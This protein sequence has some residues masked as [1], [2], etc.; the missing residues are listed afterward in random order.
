MDIDH[1]TL[2]DLSV[3]HPEENLSL[4]DKFDRTRTTG[5]RE[6]LRKLFTTPLN[7]IAEIRETQ[8]VLKAIALHEAQW[9]KK[10]SNGSVMMIHKFFETAV[11]AIPGY[12]STTEAYMYKLLH[13]PDYGLVKFSAGHAFDFLSGMKQITDIFSGADCPGILSDLIKRIRDIINKPQLEEVWRYEKAED[14]S[15]A[16]MLAFASYVRYHFK[17]LL[18]ELI[19]IYSLLDAWYGM[20]QAVK[21]NGL[22]YPEF[23]ESASPLLQLSNLFHPLLAHPVPYDVELNE[24]KN[25]IFL[26]GANMAGKSTFI[27]SVGVAIYLAHL[28]MG[29]PASSM[30]MSL[31][32]GLLTNINV[33]DNIVKGESYFYSEVTRVKNTV[34]KVTD[35]RKWMVLI[36]ELFKGTNIQDAM[37]CS[38]E[39]INGLVRVRDSFFILSTH[40]Y[41]ISDDL[42]Q[43]SN[44]DFQYFETEVKGDKLEF[45]Y[46]LKPGISNDRLGYFILK[47]EKVIEL[48]EKI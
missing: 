18:Y 9:P 48:L 39:V 31:F 24:N 12:P 16:R 23:V 36:D 13:G 5:G 26:T 4:F 45:S 28:G 44:I 46:H 25:F 37:K 22:V 43:H 20:A 3:F 42:K 30:R 40:L 27:K 2:E 38:T 33:K 17:N 41:E 15:I 29:V 1:T 21:D 8:Q 47:S 10:I 14:L 34:L 32:D 19:D 7:S 11:D 35:G 6:A